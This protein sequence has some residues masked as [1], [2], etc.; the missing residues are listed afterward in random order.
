MNSQYVDGLDGFFVVLYIYYIS[1]FSPIYTFSILLNIKRKKKVSNV[2]KPSKCLRIFIEAIY[3]QF[4]CMNM[5]SSDGFD[6]NHYFYG[7]A[8]TVAKITAGA[9]KCKENASSLVAGNTFGCRSDVKRKEVL[10]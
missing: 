9:V 3:T 1:L 6:S 8:S 7:K 5:D 4:F 2:S 10:E